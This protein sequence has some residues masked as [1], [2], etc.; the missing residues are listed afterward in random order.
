MERVEV[1][2]DNETAQCELRV[3]HGMPHV[4]VASARPPIT[5]RLNGIPFGEMETA[6]LRCV[7]VHP[8][9]GRSERAVELVLHNDNDHVDV[10]WPFAPLGDGE[11][12]AV[13]VRVQVSGTWT[14]WSEQVPVHAGILSAEGWTGRWITPVSI[15]GL[16]EPAPVFETDLILPATRRALL[17]VTAQGILVAHIN[18]LRVGD[19]HLA[20]GWT[21][22]QHRYASRT[23]DVT[24]LLREGDNVVEI[25]V[26]NGWHRGQLVWPDNL[27][28]YGPDLAVSVQLDVLDDDGRWSRHTSNDSWKCRNSPV[29]SDDLYDGQTTDHRVPLL[30][31]HGAVAAFS[32]VREVE[33]ASVVEPSENP[34]VRQVDLLLPRAE[35]TSP[36][37]AR[38]LDFGENI[39]GW[40]RID[41]RG[42]HPNAEIR[43]RHAEVLEDGELGTR[44]LRSAQATDVHIRAEHGGQ[45]EPVLTFHGFR[46]VEVD[47]A[48]DLDLHRFTAVVIASDIRRTGSW[49]TSDE[50]LNRLHDNVVRSMRGNFVALP[51]DCPQRDERLGWTGDAQI[52]SPTATFLADTRTF[53]SSW[54]RDLALEQGSDGGVPSIVP[55]VL[56]QPESASAAGWGDA[57]VVLPWV[58]W[59]AHGDRTALRQQYPSMQAWVEHVRRLAGGGV[60]EGG[61]QYGDW[62]DPTAPPEDAAAVK[63]DPGVV[64]TAHYARSAR[65]LSQAAAVLG[66]GGDALIYAS[67]ADQIIL[68]FRERYV[69]SDGV[70]FS[71]CPTVYALSIAFD[72][73]DAT[74]RAQAGDRLAVLVQEAAHVIETGFLGT[75][76]LLDALTDTG[77]LEDAYQLLM[78][79]ERPSWLYAVR[80]GATTIWERWDSMLPDGSINPGSMTSFNHYAYGA[81]A[82]WMHRVIGGLSALE[83]GYRRVRIAPRP[84]GGLTSASTQL[85]TAFGRV[86]ADWKLE[87]DNQIVVDLEVPFGCEAEVSLPDESLTVV[88]HGRHRFTSSV[89]RAKH[90]LSAG[91]MAR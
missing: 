4:P 1:R 36:G 45:L 67:L 71:D 20:P 23:H 57:A 46:Y 19:E 24:E 55:D 83:P 54:L 49:R 61:F 18:G 90:T 80:M 58:L 3:G 79:D 44:P 39:V 82:D 68:A 16:D 78:Q 31:S 40:V 6:E 60:W 47:G 21:A 42:G 69:A 63:A 43:L 81:V 87:G 53:Y 86:A 64:A 88:S 84:G 62:L 56:Y 65:L 85:E 22:Y 34:P 70:I 74:Q 59:E 73:L 17:T 33:T 76:V 48:D 41:D 77:H 75:P 13:S 30:R 15:G 10:Q 72:L 9:V 66:K 50:R 14:E 25:L 32:P 11:S 7:P 5:W 26:G 52:F 91:R 27:A 12:V 38:I 89:R 35:F 37:G 28:V 8:A 51:T 2:V 29:L